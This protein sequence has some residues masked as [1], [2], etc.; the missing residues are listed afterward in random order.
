METIHYKR[1][2]GAVAALDWGRSHE[3]TAREAYMN[4]N[5]GGDTYHID[6]TG[7]HICTEHPWLA[8]SPDGL[9]EDPSEVEGRNQGIL[10]IKC[11]YSARTL[12]PEAACQ[13]LNRFC[14]NL[15]DGRVSLKKTHNY[16]F[17]V[18]GQLAITQR[19]WCDFCIWTPHGISV[20][21][22]TRDNAF[23][24]NKMFPKLKKF[25]LKY[26]LPEMADPM[27]LTG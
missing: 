9:V 16:Y 10:E 6:R 13:E 7:I 12:T 8:A 1:P 27:F 11:P 19:P 17:Q 18:Q 2:P 23:W 25:Y 21:R 24:E 15:V 3:D 4:S 14:S 20:E 26:Y 22:I 5:T